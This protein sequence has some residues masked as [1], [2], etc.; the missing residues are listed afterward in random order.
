MSAGDGEWRGLRSCCAI[1]LGLT[2]VELW[3]YSS[4]MMRKTI[5]VVTNC[6]DF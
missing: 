6:S 5:S 3:L 1:A 4:L 2:S